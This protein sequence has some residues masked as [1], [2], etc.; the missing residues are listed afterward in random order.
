MSSFERGDVAK[1]QTFIAY[2]EEA[3]KVFADIRRRFYEINEILLGNW[4]GTGAD[5]YR[6]VSDHIMEKVGSISDTLD[7]IVEEMLVDLTRSY[8]E[9]DNALDEYNRQSAEL[10]DATANGIKGC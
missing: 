9:M 10:D 6:Y 2:K 4:E 7:I 5:A 1:L 3:K 8:E